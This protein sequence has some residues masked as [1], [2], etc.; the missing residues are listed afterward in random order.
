MSKFTQILQIAFD[1][2]VGYVEKNDLEAFRLYD[3]ESDKLTEV[4][5]DIYRDWAVIHVFAQIPDKKIFSVIETLY[6]DFNAK[7][8][9]VKDRTKDGLKNLEQGF[10]FGEK[11][12]EEFIVK[13]FECKYLVNLEGHIDTGLFLDNREFRRI[14]LNESKRKRIL[15]LFSYTGTT[16]VA[17]AKGGA[18]ETVSVDVSN[19]YS[20]WTRQNFEINAADLM[21]NKIITQDVVSFLNSEKGKPEKYDIII[22][23][24]PTFS[25]SKKGVFSV[26]KDHVQLINDCL[27]CLNWGGKII[28]SNHCK[29]FH[30]A[31]PKIRGKIRGTTNK[32]VPPDFV[33]NTHNSYTIIH[34]GKWERKVR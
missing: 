25:T 30:M 10:V 29:D 22:V 9:Y 27:Y 31:K 16:S 4:A 32:T 3:R 14:A 21:S 34:S 2:R 11:H 19:T 20:D 5:V 17:A 26:Q 23:D 8:I 18:R 15:N 28:F 33:R 1:Q 24:P 12:P 13:E 7:G 6:K